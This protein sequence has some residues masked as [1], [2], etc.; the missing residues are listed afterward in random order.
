MPFNAPQWFVPFISEYRSFWV[1]IGII[2]TYLSLLATATFYLRK[3]LGVRAFR[4][5]HYLS[6]AGFFGVLLHIWF[7]ETDTGLFSTRLMYLLAGLSVV[8][9]TAYRLMLR[10][11]S[12]NCGVKLVQEN[13]MQYEQMNQKYV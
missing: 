11:L 7:A 10:R 12:R 9:M 6:F 5:I 2:G 1:G 8:F 13:S 3:W 4:V